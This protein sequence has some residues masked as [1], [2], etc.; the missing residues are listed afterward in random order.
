MFGEG[1]WSGDGPR[2]RAAAGCAP[3]LRRSGGGRRRGSAE[4]ELGE[5]LV[6]LTPRGRCDQILAAGF[7]SLD[8]GGALASLPR[9]VPPLARCDTVAAQRPGPALRAGRV[10][11]GRPV[12]RVVRRYCAMVAL[13]ARR[14]RRAMVARRRCWRRWRRWRR[15][16]VSTRRK[17]RRVCAQPSPPT[18]PAT[19]G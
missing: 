14:W 12:G 5:M 11:P 17:R 13:T 3:R 16:W 1:A 7:A 8:G 2:E 19:D 15:V 6:S 18:T 10:A 4:V 9:L